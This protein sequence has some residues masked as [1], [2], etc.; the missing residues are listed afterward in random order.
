M[1]DIAAEL[2][3]GSTGNWRCVANFTPQESA[4]ST[5]ATTGLAYRRQQ[6]ARLA[7]LRHFRNG[8]AERREI[9]AVCVIPFA[10][11]IVT[12]LDTTESQETERS[13]C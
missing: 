9:A 7:P 4:G 5:G 11:A 1:G 3:G 13:V 8:T 6:Q 12:I 10:A 2:N